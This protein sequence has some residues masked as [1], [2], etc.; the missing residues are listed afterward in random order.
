MKNV[1][2]VM[3]ITST[4]CSLVAGMCGAISQCIEVVNALKGA[5]Q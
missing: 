2:R 3:T 5:K 1:I 4:I